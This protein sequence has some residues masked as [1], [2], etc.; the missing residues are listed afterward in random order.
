MKNVSNNLN[1]QIAG[2]ISDAIVRLATL[3]TDQEFETIK[4]IADSFLEIDDLDKNN[5]AFYRIETMFS[6]IADKDPNWPIGFLEKRIEQFD[7]KKKESQ[8]YDAIP[9]SLFHAFK[10]LKKNEKYKDILRRVR[11]W[12][13]K[14]GWYHFE[15]PKVLTDVHPS[16]TR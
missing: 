3:F 11:D 12:T 2:E 14:G 9:Y 13:S 7:E 1:A 4:Q 8:D 10:D 15:A 16:I 6:L 5:S